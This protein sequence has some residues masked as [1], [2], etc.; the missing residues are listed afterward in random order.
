MTPQYQTQFYQEEPRIYGDCMRAVFASLLDLPIQEVPHFLEQAEGR[1]YECY[2]AVEEFLLKHGYEIAWQTLLVY[3]WRPGM[4]DVYHFMSGPSPRNPNIGHAVVGKN[5][6]P[7]FD[8]HP[9]GTM[10]AEPKGRWHS[11]FLR[12]IQ[13]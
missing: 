12:K 13:S 1:A 4:P 8:P 2:N 5:G 11:S 3:Y 7:F 9:D 6:V 10:L